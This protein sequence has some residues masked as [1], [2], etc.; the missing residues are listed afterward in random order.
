MVGLRTRRQRSLLR[1][2]P[3]YGRHTALRI[4]CTGHIH[5]TQCGLKLFPQRAAQRGYSTSSFSC[6]P[7]SSG[8]PLQNPCREAKGLQQHIA[9]APFNRREAA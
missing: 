8:L 2:V 3:M 5:D 1:N 9:D 6:L 7:T 4:V